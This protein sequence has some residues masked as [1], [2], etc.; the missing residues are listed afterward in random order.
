MWQAILGERYAINGSDQNVDGDSVQWKA[1]KTQT[2]YSRSSVRR[3]WGKLGPGKL[4]Q[5]N[6]GL[7]QNYSKIP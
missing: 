2:Q 4:G 5:K 3:G 1:G 7:F 6:K